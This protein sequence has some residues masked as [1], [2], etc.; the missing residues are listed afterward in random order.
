MRRSRIV[1]EECINL[2]DDSVGRV[3]AK[4]DQV[5]PRGG[6]VHQVLGSPE[7]VLSATNGIL[8]IGNTVEREAIVSTVNGRRIGDG[9]VSDR[10]AVCTRISGRVVQEASNARTR[11]EPE[12]IG[13]DSTRKSEK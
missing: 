1:G 7:A 6:P 4:L 2:L 11:S 9:K 3:V 8:G 12:A 5:G 10:I 13:P